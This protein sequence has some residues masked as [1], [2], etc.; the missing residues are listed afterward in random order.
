MRMGA[1]G[2]IFI[3]FYK[4]NIKTP[5]NNFNIFQKASPYNIYTRFFVK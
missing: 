4:T 5:S 3:A 1:V 2:E